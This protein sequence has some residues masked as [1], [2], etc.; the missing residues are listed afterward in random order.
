MHLRR[1]CSM[2]QTRATS[3]QPDLTITAEP[4]AYSGLHQTPLSTE[5]RCDAYHISHRG[6]HEAHSGC[7]NALSCLVDL[8]S[9]PAFCSTRT[10]VRTAILGSKY[11]SLDVRGVVRALKDKYPYY[12]RADRERELEV[13]TWLI[14]Y[15]TQVGFD[16][17]P[18][19]VQ[20][21]VLW[22]T[23]WPQIISLS[24][25]RASRNF[26]GKCSIRC[27]LTVDAHLWR[28]LDPTLLHA[29]YSLCPMGCVRGRSR[30]T[31]RSRPH[32]YTTTTTYRIAPRRLCTN[33]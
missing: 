28:G 22:R 12:R 9:A 26:C 3:V 30:T 24:L 8:D 15:P 33:R 27:E 25:S 7:P 17:T 5:R 20:K 1:P 16:A 31:P 19:P 29:R 14:L 6:L 23:R 10:L 4:Y 2:A 18:S 13:R 32:F 11:G 21:S